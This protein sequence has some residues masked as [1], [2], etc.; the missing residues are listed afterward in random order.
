VLKGK[1]KTKR[2]WRKVGGLTNE[3]TDFA[4]I[5]ICNKATE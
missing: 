1:K 4:T 3:E 5:I 2:E